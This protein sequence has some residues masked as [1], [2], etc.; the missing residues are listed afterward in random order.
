MAILDIFFLHTDRGGS[1][2]GTTTKKRW[3]WILAA[4]VILVLAGM[5]AL[6]L[7]FT[8][9]RLKALIVPEIESAT[10]RTVGIE[11]VSFSFFPGIGITLNGFTLS[12]P[13]G[14][15]F[16]NP[17]L[18]SV[19]K[20]FIDVELMPL[21]GKRL[22]VDN[23]VLTDPVAY[24]DVTPDGRRNTSAGGGA[25]IVGDAAGAGTAGGEPPPQSG[26]LLLSNMEISNGRIESFNRKL[27]SRWV[28]SGLRQTLRLTTD[29]AANTAT[30]EGES[31]IREFSYG[32]GSSWYVENLPLAATERLI[33]R[34]A[35]DR[36]EV[37]DVSLRLKEVPVRVSGS[38]SGLR[39]E[40][41]TIEL[42]ME[43]P[44]LTV[45]R[46]LSLLPAAATKS[47]SEMS[48]TG[49][50]SLSMKISG[51]SNDTL[52]P[53]VKGSFTVSGGT[54]RYGS[55]AKSITGVAFDGVLE[56]PEAPVG[57]KEAGTLTLRTFAATL[58][59]NALTG[60]LTVSGFGD[61][62]V[63]AGL[64]GNV[65]LGEI[66]QY[67]PL[68]EG[69]Q[70]SGSA[71]CD[72]SINGRPLKA[73]GLR[74]SGGMKFNDVSYSTPTMT[75]PLRK[76]N[77][78]VKFDN[79][80]LLMKNLTM[81]L[82][83]SDM[84]IDATLRNYS[85]LMMDGGGKA[86]PRPSLEFALK[87]RILNTA[88]LPASDGDPAGS[89]RAGGGGTAAGGSGTGSL[90]LPAIDMA[91]TVEVETLRTE[92]FTFTNTKGGIA[93]K[94]GI[95]K[96]KD[97]RLDVFGGSVETSGNLDLRDPS[98]RP[99]DLNLDVKNVESNSMLSP[100]TTF[101]KYLFGKLTLSTSMKGDL[102]DTL[103]ISTT[104]L[105]G[106]GTA[107]VADGKLTGL[108]LLEKLAG[109]LS[110]DRLKEVDFKN[111]TQSF[112]VADGRLN[113][114]DL[115]IGGNDANI[116][117]NGVHGLDGSV[118]YSMNINIPRDVAGKITPRGVPAELV[119]FFSDKEGNMSFDFLV[120]GQSA[121]PSLKLD[122]RAQENLLKQRMGE[123]AAKKLT[124]PLKK[125]AEGLKKL[126]KP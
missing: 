81:V 53:G 111:W 66:H 124:D 72:V 120:T 40:T 70:L 3:P 105:T 85:A 35:E 31:D 100:F 104:S 68:P 95:A 57:D 2:M 52:N 60:N 42:E 117:V 55:L 43:S 126:I 54:V 4:P 49:T 103:G 5:L 41:S 51:R 108:P 79:Q 86:A 65:A 112:S 36:L 78:E 116:T 6:K 69:T 90:L 10:H 12:N 82:G 121:S 64:K 1:Q 50:A 47:A 80:L 114:K 44:D 77:G 26:A 89:G 22:V 97:L 24:L 20:L 73:D 99:F 92:K 87:S 67:Y 93:V 48:A 33:Y 25:R 63:N 30:L 37:A 74:A 13:A 75:R 76:L 46:L 58:G 18:F 34:A 9:E 38:V 102:D 88:D 56:I 61:P 17:Y 83:G 119:Q 59:A 32:T 123:E 106:A 122:T 71:S 107:L 27:D 23:L 14:G 7:Y 21:L 118:D 94:D 109:F 110:A 84:K 39:E 91:G 45:E 125:A 8:D 96:L 29:A 115:K 98:K 113:V 28:I 15:E 101:G 62:A 16:P 11:D 19:K